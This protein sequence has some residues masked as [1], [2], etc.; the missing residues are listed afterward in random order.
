MLG[1]FKKKKIFIETLLN[2]RDLNNFPSST[3]ILL[4]PR[5]KSKIHYNLSY[6]KRFIFPLAWYL[7]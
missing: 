4:Y 2:V 1:K 5:N 7:M 3:D 6:Y